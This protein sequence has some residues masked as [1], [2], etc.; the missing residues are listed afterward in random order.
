VRTRSVG[1]FRATELDATVP[2]ADVSEHTHDEAHFVLV[3][4]GAYAST[5][6]HKTESSDAPLL[7]F[8]DNQFRR[9]AAASLDHEAGGGTHRSGIGR[10]HAEQTLITG[11]VGRQ[12]FRTR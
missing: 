3:L 8:H 11:R 2:A 6:R 10:A 9:T 5:A 12:G 4:R 1:A 7:M